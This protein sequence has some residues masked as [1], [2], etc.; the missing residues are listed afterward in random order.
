MEIGGGRGGLKI[1]ARKEGVRRNRGGL[2]RNGGLPY[3]EAFL[4]IPH[5]VT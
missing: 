5:D 1:F 2:S 4:E 3:I